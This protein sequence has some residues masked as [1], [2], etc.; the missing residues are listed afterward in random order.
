MLSTTPFI[1]FVFSFLSF[2]EAAFKICKKER[3]KKNLNEGGKRIP[4]LS[5]GEP[6][7][8]FSPPSLHPSLAPEQNGFTFFPFYFLYILS[9]CFIFAFCPCFC[10]VLKENPTPFTQQVNKKAL[11]VHYACLYGVGV[12]C[13]LQE[14][15]GCAFYAVL[16]FL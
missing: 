16:S 4:H 15:Q 10:F 5:G 12:G 9:G 7:L 2:Y 1:P 6:G 3:K 8:P 13:A 14:F 11:S